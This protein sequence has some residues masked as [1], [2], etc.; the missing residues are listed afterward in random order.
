MKTIK[1][2]P[3]WICFDCGDKYCNG[4]TDDVRTGHEGRCGVCGR[5]RNVTEPRDFGHIDESKLRVKERPQLVLR[6]CGH[7]R[8]ITA[9]T[10]NGA[11]M[12]ICDVCKL[13]DTPETLQPA[14]KKSKKMV[15]KRETGRLLEIFYCRDCDSCLDVGKVGWCKCGRTNRRMRFQS[16]VNNTIPK[17]CPLPVSQ[18]QTTVR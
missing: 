15:V 4:I 6:K 12:W 17:W 18:K 7:C 16:S 2:Y 14:R 5:M 10:I 3:A 9:H 1:N 13:D 11:G 8:R